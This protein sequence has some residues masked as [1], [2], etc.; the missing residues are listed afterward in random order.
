MW[1][2]VSYK[3]VYKISCALI[4]QPSIFIFINISDF[5][6]SLILRWR[7]RK[8]NIVFT[9]ILKEF[10]DFMF[11][12]N[13]W[14]MRTVWVCLSVCLCVCVSVCMSV[15]VS[16][17]LCVCTFPKRIHPRPTDIRPPLQQGLCL[18]VDYNFLK[19]RPISQP[20]SPPTP[21]L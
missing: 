4:K 15:W 17:C 11:S 14:F 1:A 18:Y 6:W 10:L 20:H 2:Q 8:P 9:I 16:V 19:E 3:K 12:R 21:P 13:V 7:G 5:I